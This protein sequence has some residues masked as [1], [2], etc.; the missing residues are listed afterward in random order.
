[1]P[2]SVEVLADETTSERP[3]S[4]PF[5]RPAAPKLR[6][7]GVGDYLYKE[8]EPRTNVYRV[9]KG[10]VA[11]F[12]R[13]LGRPANIIEMAS[14]GGY[15]GLGCLEQHR[16]NT[17]AVVDSIV[18]ILPKS[19]FAL[20][21]E[22]DPRLR[23]IQDDAI[24][25]DFESGKALAND[26]GRSAPIECVAAFLVAVSRQ[27]AYEGRDPTIVSDSLKCGIV[28]NLLDMDISTLSRALLKLQGLGLVE[29][30]PAAG[31]HLKDIE[32]LERIAYGDVQGIAATLGALPG[33]AQIESQ[34][35]GVSTLS[36]L[37]QLAA[38]S[39]AI[40]PSS[41]TGELREAAWLISVI[42]G[43][44]VIGVGLAVMIAI[45]LA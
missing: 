40:Y 25:K 3:Q 13:R 20:L 2:Q 14:Q 19:E 41:S 17:R 26:R 1:M 45:A 28:T 12:E 34:P 30:Y 24:K 18:S 5:T 42:G 10:V 11:V 16:D 22:G 4:K 32:A 6:V 38:R 27:N 23:K 35:C 15:V 8:A 39:G 44:S 9:E 43:L 29:Q 36:L 37:R 33:G 31:L 21:V 7:L